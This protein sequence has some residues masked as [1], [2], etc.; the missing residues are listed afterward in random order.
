MNA[1]AAN[2]FAIDQIQSARYGA[3]TVTYTWGPGALAAG[4]TTVFDVQGWNRNES[5]NAYVI[6]EAVAATQN[7]GVQLLWTADGNSSDQGQGWTDG[8]PAGMRMAP[9]GIVAQNSIQLVIN[10]LTGAQVNSFQLTYTVTVLP[11]SAAEALLRFGQEGLD[12][13]QTEA[14]DALPVQNGEDGL[15]QVLGL[16]QKG[17]L[18]I[19]RRR[20]LDVLWRNRFIA[21]A[22][23]SL[24]LHLT[25]TGG[26]AA[27]T[28]TYNVPPGEVWVLEGLAAEGAP[29]G[30]TLTTQRGNDVGYVQLNTA[31]F[32]Q[33][34]EQ[35]W[36]LWVPFVNHLI[37]SVTGTAQTY[38][39]RPDIRRYSLS[40]LLKIHMGITKKPATNHAKVWAGLQ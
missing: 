35:A 25:V 24:G 4:Q 15:A 9:L 5:Q 1:L 39:V 17:T 7:A 27:P 34:D 6:V 37:L 31:A 11:M 30:G 26:A 20:Y 40:T 33:A 16:L 18:P 29:A 36:P 23:A 3:E 28:K 22:P 14:L 8:L 10:N 21:P 32:T 19:A 2:V 13:V 38:A 12:E